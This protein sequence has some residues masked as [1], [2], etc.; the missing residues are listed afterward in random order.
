[1]SRHISWRGL[2]NEWPI[3][4]AAHAG[5]H[6]FCKSLD[7]ALLYS[8]SSQ[9]SSI[10][11]LSFVTNGGRILGVLYG[12]N[13]GTPDNQ[14]SD[15]RI[16]ARWLQKKVVI[17]NSSGVKYLA[18]GSYDPDRQWFSAPSGSLDGTIVVYAEDGITPLGS[19]TVSRAPGAAY[20]LLLRQK[21]ISKET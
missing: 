2:W 9:D 6:D 13:T 4:I 16:F 18:Q 20:S 1:M 14:F 11:S 7:R 8:Q 19:S 15:Y 3:R 17:T 5:F 12:A 10:D 21:N